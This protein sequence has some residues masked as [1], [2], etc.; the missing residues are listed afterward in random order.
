MI[1]DPADLI[2][3]LT[4]TEKWAQERGMMSVEGDPALERYDSLNIRAENIRKAW[5]RNH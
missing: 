4:K 3:A 5:H 1:K 2:S